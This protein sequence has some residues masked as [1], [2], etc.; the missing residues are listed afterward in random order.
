MHHSYVRCGGLNI[1]AGKSGHFSTDWILLDMRYNKDNDTMCNRG[2]VENVESS[3][4]MVASPGIHAPVS[5]LQLQS[6]T[7]SN[8]IL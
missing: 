5:V 4:R 3:W 8:V 7:R 1:V 2:N 6:F